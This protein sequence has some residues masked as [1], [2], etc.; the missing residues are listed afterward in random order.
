[1]ARLIIEEEQ[2][3]RY[4]RLTDAVTTIGR[5]DTNS[6]Q[7]TDV[8][9]S[10]C[11]CQLTQHNG[12]FV[13]VDLESQNG[14]W[15][16]DLRIEDSIA[17]TG[18]DVIQIGQTRITLDLQSHSHRLPAVDRPLSDTR[19]AVVESTPR[20]R[21]RRRGVSTHARAR[22]RKKVTQYE[23][24]QTEDVM[25][26][27]RTTL[28]ETLLQ[29][30]KDYG[31]DGALEA[32]AIFEQH[33]EESTVLSQAFE[34]AEKLERVQEI[35]QA[36]N[37]ELDL[38]KL[39]ELIMDAVIELTQAD[40]GFLLL[41]E[42]NQ[43]NVEI[44]RNFGR[45]SL[46]NPDYQMS[47]SIAKKVASTGAAV[48]STDAQS[49]DRFTEFMSVLDLR[50]RSV[51]CLP[52]RSSGEVIGVVYL[53]NSLQSGLFEKDDLQIL[54][55]FCDQAGIAIENA[56][57]HR[58]NRQKKEE[59]E[60]LNKLLEAKVA[61]QAQSLEEARGIIDQQRTQLETKYNYDNIIGVSEPMRR[62]FL[63]M[64]KITDSNA[65]VFIHGESG[66]G[67]ELV[68]RAIHFNGPRKRMR[69]VS[70]NCGA[71]S[72]NLLESEL[73]GYMKGAFTG[74]HKDKK[75]LFEQA[76]DGT[77]FL[78]EIG[79]MSSEMQKKLLRALQEGEIRPV[80]S[81]EK[82][83]VDVRI[84]SAS[85]KDLRQLVE[86]GTFREDLYY[87]VNVFRV[88]LPPLRDR[89]EDIPA[90]LEHLLEKICR[91][92]KTDQPEVDKETLRLLMNY[93]WPGNVR[94][95]ENE[96][97]RAVALSGQVITP[98]SLSEQIRRERGRRFDSTVLEG[99]T[100]KEIVKET[101]SEIEKDIIE[102]V[103]EAC[104]WKK[105]ETAKRLGVS[106]PTL[107]AKLD[108]YDIQIPSRR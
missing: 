29:L 82:V 87:R 15:L 42:E 59:V 53:D 43:M 24:K 85:N 86:Q 21:L 98:D 40:R 97:H 77:L 46:K 93:N 72:E 28:D 48:I 81:K 31:D 101:T 55:P 44:A 62:I 79:D 14:T 8:K 23:T 92:N 64:D 37:S 63:L 5:A 66:T 27:L 80:G 102:M 91:E 58:E 13:L 54:E 107:D 75:G 106:R 90:L 12:D 47:R 49:D 32:A 35:N 108:A 60:Q 78:D 84:L 67:K 39:L 68:A 103:L 88:E 50:L 76:N 3:K 11:H 96:I 45:E 16:N 26:G 89:K 71:I 19:P 17:L 18:G 104:G 10:R 6:I 74:A 41:H 4:H 2:E 22:R 105:S 69:F 83:Q 57:L 25:I 99:R 94:E 34:W 38:H 30:M 20:S 1:M 51:L 61:R 56:R 95:L 65:P 73:F 36:I 33:L 100:L 52:L 7:I 70:E 9:S